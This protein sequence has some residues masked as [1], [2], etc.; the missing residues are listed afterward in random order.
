[1]PFAADYKSMSTTEMKRCVSRYKKMRD[2]AQ[3]LLDTCGRAYTS[4]TKQELRSIRRFADKGIQ[5]GFAA[6]EKAEAKKAKMKKG[7]K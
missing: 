5:S 1:M 3:A 6:I 2:N 7:K 4:K